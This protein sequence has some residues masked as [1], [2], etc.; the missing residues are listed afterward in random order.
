MKPSDLLF[1]IVDFLAFLVPGMIFTSSI[2]INLEKPDNVWLEAFPSAVTLGFILLS[3]IF[4]H[5]IHFA[6]ATLFNGIYNRQFLPAKVKSEK[7]AALIA[8]AEE[9]IK[10]VVPSYTDAIRAATVY[11]KLHH[12]ALVN[13]L[14]KYAANEKLFRSLALLSLYLSF[15][16]PVFYHLN[17]IDSTRLAFII[18]SLVVMVYLSYR[19]FANQRWQRLLF[20][21]E[22]IAVLA[23]KTLKPD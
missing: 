15:Y 16:M 19:R 6:S 11:L 1:G 13:D 3:Y 17:K 8:D 4:G 12:P 5:Y 7:N 9:A 23:G 2:L 20:T 10:R 21:Y 14:D 22:A 18:P